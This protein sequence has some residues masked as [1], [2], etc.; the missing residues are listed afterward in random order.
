MWRERLGTSRALRIGLAW[1]GTPSPYNRAVPLE[2]LRPLVQRP[3]C[4]LH[5]L[6]TEIWPAD[7]IASNALPGVHDHRDELADF[8][9]T[10]A[11][12]SLMDL[13][14]SI[15][16]DYRWMLGRADCPW[17]PAMR[18]LRQPAQRDWQSV[19]DAV[20]QKRDTLP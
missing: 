11:R 2:L 15:D 7:R 3:D 16:T 14:I 8:A 6:Q 4:E 9:D 5:V 1:S 10:A 19:V 13:M 12:V 18:P 17:N 20:M